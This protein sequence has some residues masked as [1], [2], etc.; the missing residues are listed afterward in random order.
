MRT[1]RR[2]FQRSRFTRFKFLQKLYDPEQ[3][4]DDLMEAMPLEVHDSL[5]GVE[6]YVPEESVASFYR[7]IYQMKSFTCGFDGWFQE[8]VGKVVNYIENTWTGML[9]NREKEHVVEG[10]IETCAEIVAVTH[11]ENIKIS[12]T[13][14]NEMGV[15]IA[16]DIYDANSAEMQIELVQSGDIFG[17]KLN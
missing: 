8:Y 1:W 2:N 7:N 3:N 14:L 12:I 15:I 13:E 16:E 4:F 6:L 11:L 9:N 17:T 5:D 10:R